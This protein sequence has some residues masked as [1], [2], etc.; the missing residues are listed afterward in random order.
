M[1]PTP[2]IL[3]AALAALAPLP[4]AEG[5]ADANTAADPNATAFLRSCSG[6]HTI[7]RGKLTGPDLVSAKTLAPSALDAAL[8]RMRSKVIGTFDASLIAALLRDAAAAARLDREQQRQNK[9]A[10][11]KLDPPDAAVG[12][13]LFQG[14]RR[15]AAGG[16]ACASCHSV[17][18]GPMGNSPFLGPDLHDVY[19]RYGRDSLR[20]ACQQPGFKIMSALYKDH[21]V[22]RQEAVHLVAFFAALEKEPPAP[23]EFPLHPVAALGALLFFA[24]LAVAYRGRLRSVRARIT[25]AAR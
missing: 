25:G 14:Q 1:K 3:F 5:G 12:R 6:C 8:E 10:E 16:T 23:N 2:W 7:G 11:A 19:K 4:A 22:T 9:L 20:V 18:P 24:G 15:L 17:R 21:P 13:A